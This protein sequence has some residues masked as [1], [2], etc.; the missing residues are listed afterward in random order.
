MIIISL[1]NNTTTIQIVYAMLYLNYLTFYDEYNYQSTRHMA[2]K[3]LS[4][5]PR[6]TPPRH[7]AA[8]E[9]EVPSRVHQKE[10]KNKTQSE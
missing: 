3:S 7:S 2:E 5:T 6:P 10:K 1:T 9:V 8:R 4:K